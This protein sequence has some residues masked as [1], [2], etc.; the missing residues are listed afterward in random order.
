MGYMMKSARLIPETAIS[1]IGAFA[2]LVS[3]PCVLFRAVAALDFGTVQVDVV[4]ALILGKIILLLIS[5]LVGKIVGK[6]DGPGGGELAGGCFALLTTNSDDLGLGLPVLGAIFPPKLV[7]MCYVLS[8]VQMIIFNPLIFMLFGIGATKRDTPPGEPQA[9][10]H[11]IVLAVLRGLTKNFVICS[12]VLGLAYNAAFGGLK[13]AS[14]PFFLDD[15]CVLLGS[16]FGPMVLYMAGAA[17]VGSFEKLAALNSALMPLLTVLLKSILLPTIVMSLLSLFGASRSTMDFAF[18]F[19]CLPTAGSTL[20]FAAAYR[21]SDELKSLLSAGL[22][23][24]KLLGFPLLF[25]SAAIFKTKDVHDVLELEER[26]AVWLHSS[27]RRRSCRSSP[28]PRGSRRGAAAPCASSTCSASSPSGTMS[29]PPR[30]LSA[31]PRPPRSLA[32]SPSAGGRRTR[33]S[34]SP[35]SR[36]RRRRPRACGVPT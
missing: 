4:V 9:S 13:G 20:V 14:L 8:A 27:R 23:L 35:P 25:L 30:A 22:A 2:G 15:L 34:C 32:R 11:E 3:L 17:N 29:P 16:A 36:G 31:S 6:S 10:N 21:P 33:C 18:A 19:N 26:L 5:A 1:G 24:G 28:P 7:N 12:V